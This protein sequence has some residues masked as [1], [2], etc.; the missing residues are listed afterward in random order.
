MNRGIPVETGTPPISQRAVAQPSLYADTGY[1][2]HMNEHRRHIDRALELARAGME[3]GAG[4]P[5]G[6]VIVRDGDVVAEAHNRVLVNHDPT[7]HAE[8]EAIRLAGERLRTHELTG[9]VIYASGEPCPMCL[10]AIYWAGIET[11]HY[12]GTVDDAAG[13]DFDDRYIFD[14]LALP[15][16]QRKVRMIAMEGVA[17]K[18]A[19]LYQA[20]A[21]RQARS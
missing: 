1:N 5:F 7:A 18:V 8:I 21:D 15:P 20:W 2:S 16:S 6:A 11:V 19:P 12:A 17:D 4:Y 10:A 14:Q 13:I 3:Q 9:L